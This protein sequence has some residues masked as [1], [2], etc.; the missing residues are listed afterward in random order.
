M[1]SPSPHPLKQ[2]EN[3][4]QVTL[5][6]RSD[7]LSE[8]EYLYLLASLHPNPN[9]KKTEASSVLVNLD[10]AHPVFKSN[11]YVLYLILDK[12]RASSSV[13]R[14]TRAPS[15]NSNK[16][17]QSH[18]KDEGSVGKKRPLF[19]LGKGNKRV[20]D[21]LLFLSRRRK[22]ACQSSLNFQQEKLCTSSRPELRASSNLLRQN[23][24]DLH[25]KNNADRPL[26]DIEKP[27]ILFR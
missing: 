18:E 21:Y 22:R 20:P 23:R 2:E 3:S 9:F 17:L 24:R 15:Q 4:L 7:L 16:P 6:N 13:M 5:G 10:G 8:R 19:S 12:K 25:L 27:E 11:T 14:K 26:Q 1:R